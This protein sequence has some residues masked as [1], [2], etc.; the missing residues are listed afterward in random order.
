MYMY[1]YIYV[2]MYIP[3]SIHMHIHIHI[4]VHVH[5]LH[6]RAHVCLFLILLDLPDDLSTLVFHSCAVPTALFSF[7]RLC[8]M[9][10]AFDYFFYGVSDLVTFSATF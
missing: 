3:T 10:Y 2:F 6:G 8:C 7:R 1:V 5:I 4:H 9:L